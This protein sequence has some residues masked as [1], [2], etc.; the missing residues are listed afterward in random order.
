MTDTIT[1]VKDQCP[2][3]KGKL[4]MVEDHYYACTSCQ[5]YFIEQ[6]CCPQCKEPVDCIKG[7]GAINY[8]CRQD[9]LVS[10]HKIEYHYL[11]AN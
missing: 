2:E 11:K 9:G 7:C 1:S 4:I 6:I 5:R 8:L 3:C 10:K